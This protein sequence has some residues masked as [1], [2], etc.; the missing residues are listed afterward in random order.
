MLLKN[1][2]R[3]KLIVLLLFITIVPFGTSIVITFL[4]T[5]ESLKDQFVEEN[6]NLLYQGKIN[7]E[8]YM[9]ELKKL[10]LPFYNNVDFMNYLRYPHLDEDYMTKSTVNNVIQTILYS[11]ENIKKVNIALIEG[12]K[13]V[14]VSKRSIILYSKIPNNTDRDYF[15]K[16]KESPYHI[17]IEPMY[18]QRLDTSMA[19]KAQ[20]RDVFTI[21]RTIIDVPS[22]EILGYMSLEFEPDKIFDLSNKLFV[23]EKEEFYIFDPDG[24]VIFQSND[25]SLDEPW[26]ATLLQGEHTSG[27]MEIK[28]DTFDGML[29]YEKVSDATGGW[30]LAKRIPY[31]TAFE[32]ALGVAKINIVFGIL[33]LILV[34]LATLFVSFRITS[35]I[36]ILMH[37]IKQVEKGKMDVDFD[38][39]GN[40]E[41]GVLGDRFKQ[42]V[43]KINH[44]INR[45]YKLE[46]ENKTN[47]LKVLQSQVNPHFLYNAL[48]SIGTVAL[49]NKVPQIYTL[50]THLSKIM[51]YS[52]NMDEDVVPLSRELDYTK[53]YLLLQKER[54]G[55][56][57]HYT[58]EFDQEAL[59]IHI[60]KMILQPII[61]NY[62]KHGFDSGRERRGQL[63]LKGS[64]IEGM[65][66]IVIKDNG[67][68]IEEDRLQELKDCLTMTTNQRISGESSIGLKNIYM[69]LQLFYQHHA[70]FT[71]ENNIDEGILVTMKLPIEIGGDQNESNYH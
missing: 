55:D 26:I 8:E 40:D 10:S 64:L 4:Y 13:N 36:R 28:S 34:I 46:I 22:D 58:V 56:H 45:E 7:L 49:K 16:A 59:S 33:G 57:F 63:S 37:N 52:M 48:Q 21:H 50:V 44:L 69:R 19:L 31:R 5:K 32:S 27:T 42:M 41:I 25:V 39:L 35:P 66:V 62:F 67:T 12:D 24:N 51:R 17:Y 65:L 18:T 60:P 47:Q 38:S 14:S 61:E 6:I 1:S 30:I 43:S 20:P 53:A 70:Q 54:F 23:R 3:N 29:I 71:I 15:R 11:E 68:G 9:D 2:I